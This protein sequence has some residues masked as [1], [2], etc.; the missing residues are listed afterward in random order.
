M[1]TAWAL[2]FGCAL[3]WDSFVLPL[4]T[5]L[6]AAGLCGTFAGLLAGAAVMAIIA[7]NYHCMVNR[8]PGP[9]GAYTY[10][11]RAFGR[12]HGFLCAWF[13]CLAYMSIVWMDSVALGFVMRYMFGDAF[14]CGPVYSIDGAEV[15]LCDLGV[16]TV[17]TVAAAALCCRRRAAGFAQT[18]FATV[19]AAG[20][21]LCF[22]AAA[23]NGHAAAPV[24]QVQPGDGM[25][26]A[27]VLRIVAVV[28]WLFVGLESIS[29]LSGEFKFPTGRT[30]GVMLA[31]LAASLAAYALLTVIPVLAG[32]SDAA[33]RMPGAAQG[34]A[35]EALAFDC[36]ARTLGR[37]GT[38]AVGATLV[39]SIFTNLVGNTLAASRLISAMSADGAMPRWLGER[40]ADGSPRRAVLAIAALS[41]LVSVLGRRTI[42]I[43]MDA[44][45]VGAAVAY[46]Y[47]SAAAFK[48]AK[49]EGRRLSAAC[50]LA[51]LLLSAGII[52]IY[53]TPY[54]SSETLMST[55]AYLAI[56]LWSVAGLVHYLIVFRRDRDRRFGRSPVAWLSL[57]GT[58]LLMS[59]MWMR[60][61]TYDTTGAAFDDIAA[62]HAELCIPS[63]KGLAAGDPLTEPA[64]WREGLAARL[65]VVNRSILRGSVVQTLLIV[66]ALSLMFSL[67]KI[68]RR[69]ERELEDEKYNARNY[70]FSTISHDIRTP[71]NAIIGYSELLDSGLK[72]EAERKQ[73]LES[74]I[75]SGRTLLGLVNDVL[76][77]SKLESGKMEILP[78]PTDCAKLLNQVMD[79][80]RVTVD[81]KG[82]E[83]VCRAGGLPFL[84]LDAQRMRQI[85]FNLAGNAVKFT[86]KGRVEL[87]AS[88]ERQAGA[89]DGTFTLE[90][91]DT[92]CGI[93]EEDLKRIGSAYV[94]VGSA[95]SRNGGTGLGLAI[96]GQLA[97]A[98]SG[99]LE[100]QSEL[101]SGS[102]FRIVIPHVRVA[103]SAAAA[104]EAKNGAGTAQSARRGAIR[105]IL[106]VDDSKMNLMVLKALLKQLGDFETEVAANGREALDILERPGERPFDLVLTD[107][108]M[109]EMDGVGL[110]KAVR[111]NP[112]LSR[113]CVALV[114][115]DVEMRERA[116]PQGFDAVLLKPVTLDRLSGFLSEVAR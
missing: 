56:V 46:A 111:A 88:Y 63:M 97:K 64:G 23:V 20:V 14:P 105:R 66:L 25:S 50:G 24:A 8:H 83:F 89:E 16:S 94:Q 34:G 100:V 6:P 72:S 47:T 52:F 109:P 102:I 67:Y 3:G 108:W 92:G 79:S 73:A 62:H 77:L 9:G 44:S 76:D 95:R 38:A 71:L 15:S 12:D 55:E 13:L 2:A 57:V 99:R 75:V 45:L 26:F 116:L 103:K 78:A 96:C 54:L 110:L 35:S 68:M 18:L 101:G 39:G 10:A 33:G 37:W 7:W 91:E 22:A 4:T 29:H 17:A 28:P 98:M 32:A 40:N 70:F 11:S 19:F 59:F 21:V 1:F 82:L 85:V 36:A 5:F 107:Q 49:S 60:Q 48:S 58:V 53:V 114:T 86:E 43:I 41:L 90:V 112:A 87:R 51:G 61:T 113:T 31:A 115:A 65:S 84:E 93:G 27:K 69:R 30:I 81:K 42:G 104:A 106:L 80:F 74:I